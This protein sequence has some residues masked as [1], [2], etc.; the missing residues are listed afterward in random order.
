MDLL[1]YIEPLKNA[2]DEPDIHQWFELFSAEFDLAFYNLTISI[3]HT[4][5]TNTRVG[6]SNYPETWLREYEQQGYRHCDP[7]F[8]HCAKSITPIVWYP[9]SQLPQLP[10]NARQFLIRAR[11]FGLHKGFSVALRGRGSAI[12]MLTFNWLQDKTEQEVLSLTSAASALLPYLYESLCA[13]SLSGEKYNNVHLTKREKECVSWAC[14]GKT[15]WEISQILGL[16]ER[17]VI[18]HLTNLMRKTGTNNRQQAIA[19]TI[20]KG[21]VE[22]AF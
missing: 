10:K 22:P 20:L 5:Q 15:S 7:Y 14:D 3:P 6:F 13:I 8:Q 4:M 19:K 21:V 9:Q 2:A 11:G 18:F 1:R 12:C 16:S 17:T